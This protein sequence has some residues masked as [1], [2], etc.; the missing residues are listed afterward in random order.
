LRDKA[1]L[2]PSV[3]SR[4]DSFAQPIV[5]VLH[6]V[7]APILGAIL[8][9]VDPVVPVTPVIIGSGLGGLLP[10]PVPPVDVEREAAAKH[11]A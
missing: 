2:T 9:V 3:L 5:P 7:T 1:A 10:A 4:G 6:P 11:R 8:P